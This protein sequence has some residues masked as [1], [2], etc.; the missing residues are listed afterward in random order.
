MEKTDRHRWPSILYFTIAALLFSGFMY[1]LAIGAPNPT[2]QKSPLSARYA[3]APQKIAAPVNKIVLHANT[4]TTFGKI[5][6]KYRGLDRDYLYIDVYILELDPQ[7]GYA[8]KIPIKSA[9]K[10]FRIYEYTFALVSR[11]K[12]YISLRFIR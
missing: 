2:Q 3:S 9:R 8:Y 4:M 11:A 10:G 12:S 6:F 1:F 7:Y 5:K